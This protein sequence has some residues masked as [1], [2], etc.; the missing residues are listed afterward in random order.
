[1]EINYAELQEQQKKELCSMLERLCHPRRDDE[2]FISQRSVE[3]VD[4]YKRIVSI[5]KS[6]DVAHVY[7]ME[8]LFDGLFNED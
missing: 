4:E 2:E 1:M 5:F 8:V 6:K 3:S 7:A